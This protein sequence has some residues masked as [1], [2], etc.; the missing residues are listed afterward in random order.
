MVVSVVERQNIGQWDNE[1]YSPV[2]TDVP[3]GSIFA[4]FSQLL[5]AYSTLDVT[6]SPLAGKGTWWLLPTTPAVLPTTTF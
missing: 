2:K 3:E 4:T 5:A 6:R 1:R